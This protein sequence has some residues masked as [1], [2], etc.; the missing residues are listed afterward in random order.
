MRLPTIPAATTRT[1]NVPTSSPPTVERPEAPLEEREQRGR[2]AAPDPCRQVAGKAP[3][4]AVDD[5]V[6]VASRPRE[7][8]R[9]ERVGAGPPEQN[10]SAQLEH[11]TEVLAARLDR[12]PLLEQ[13][14]AGAQ[15]GIRDVDERAAECGCRLDRAE[16]VERHV[17]ARVDGLV[18]PAIA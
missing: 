13:L 4:G 15:R 2:G 3:H 10:E 16:A 11:A 8:V 5:G 14:H 6:E 18:R 7:A 9:Q 1:S 17:R 12:P